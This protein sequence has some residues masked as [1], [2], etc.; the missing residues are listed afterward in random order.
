MEFIDLKAQYVHLQ[1]RI[2]RRVK[3]VL[4]HGGY[5]L[6]PEVAELERG[7]ADYCGVKHAIGCANGTDALVLALKALGI[8]EGDAVF[9]TPFT[10]FATAEAIVLA[11][12]RPVFADI[13]PAVLDEVAAHLDPGRRA[14]LYDEVV[15]LGAHAL[16]TATEKGLYAEMGARAQYLDA[17]EEGGVT[18]VREGAAP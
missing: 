13:D 7:L 12:A 2:D 8:D 15:G 1:E 9:T 17:V 5:V 11:G 6:G 3:T 4:D 14:A 16:M 18:E 10:F